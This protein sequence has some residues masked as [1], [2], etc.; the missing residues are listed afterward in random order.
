MHVESSR[1]GMEGISALS[2]AEL[3]GT[4]YDLVLLDYHMPHMS[5]L[6]VAKSLETTLKK[7]PKIIALSSSIDHKLLHSVK[8][9][10]ACTEKPIRRQQLLYL[11]CRGVMDK[12]DDGGKSEFINS[13][14]EENP[15]FLRPQAPAK[16]ARSRI[17]SLVGLNCLIVEDN[18][19]NRCVL[20]DL[21]ANF[22]L[23]SK[24]V[25]NGVEALAAMDAPGADY[26]LIITGMQLKVCDNLSSHCFFALFTRYSHASVE[27][28]RLHASFA[29][30]RLHA[31]HRIAHGR[32]HLGNAHRLSGSRS[33]GIFA[34]ADPSCDVA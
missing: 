9:I 15:R 11:I 8:S 5:G 4:P 13:G 18:E 22:G 26:D 17:D 27:R 33:H 19:V 2:A 3:K 31:P 24:E 23:K 32:C 21:L 12:R 14:T 28:N 29:R 34:Q 16:T 10:V 7:V 6:D 20:R 30:A 25:V 1:S